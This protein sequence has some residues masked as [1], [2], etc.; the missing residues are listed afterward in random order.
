MK[1]LLIIIIISWSGCFE[2]GLDLTSDTAWE[3]IKKG[4]LCD[5]KIAKD[6]QYDSPPPIVEL[7][8]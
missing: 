4:D 8:T 7:G 1:F 2:G 3:D 6:M 5:M